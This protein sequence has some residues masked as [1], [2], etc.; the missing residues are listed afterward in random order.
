MHVHIYIYICREV[1][2]IVSLKP[3]FPGVGKYEVVGNRYVSITSWSYF[4]F[5]KNQTKKF[6]SL[7]YHLFLLNHELQ[8]KKL[9]NDYYI[10]WNLEL[11]IFMFYIMFVQDG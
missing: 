10:I 3:A 9:C 7:Q 5:S 1:V 11:N 4:W 6:V 8:E 2:Q